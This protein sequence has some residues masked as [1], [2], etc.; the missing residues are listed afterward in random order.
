MRMHKAVHCPRIAMI[1]GVKDEDDG[2]NDQ[3]V[4]KAKEYKFDLSRKIL[5]ISLLEKALC[6]GQ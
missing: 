5:V 2:G 1:S 3:K 4:H 6:E